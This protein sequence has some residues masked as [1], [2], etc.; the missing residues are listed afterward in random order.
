MGLGGI[1]GAA[2]GGAA[3]FGCVLEGGD[4][5]LLT[6]CRLI[7]TSHTG[8]FSS[9]TLAKKSLLPRHTGGKEVCRGGRGLS[10]ACK[11]HGLA[12]QLLSPQPSAQ[13]SSQPA[14]KK[15]QK[16]LTLFFQ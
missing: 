4:V 14:P 8:K 12:R 13:L 7:Y 11:A 10:P 9:V 15:F 16:I 2:V 5:T 3:G 6:F 1:G